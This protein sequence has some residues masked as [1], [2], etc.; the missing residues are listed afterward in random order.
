[1]HI[2]RIGL[3]SLVLVIFNRVRVCPFNMNFE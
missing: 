3:Q 2:E 1:M